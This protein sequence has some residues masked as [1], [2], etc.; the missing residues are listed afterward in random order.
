[1]FGIDDTRLDETMDDVER[2]LAEAQAAAP[3]AFDVGLAPHAPYTVS[4]LLYQRV[5]QLARSAASRS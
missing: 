5:S 3:P 2:R 4:S 1:M